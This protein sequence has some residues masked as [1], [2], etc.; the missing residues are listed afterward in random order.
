[1][2]ENNKKYDMNLIKIEVLNLGIQDISNYELEDTSFKEIERLTINKPYNCSK[3]PFN[4]KP[5]CQRR[6]YITILHCTSSTNNKN[7]SLYNKSKKI[8]SPYDISLGSR[9]NFVVSTLFILQML[10]LCFILFLLSIFSSND[11]F[12]YHKTIIT[13]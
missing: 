7:C 13:F 1:M 3:N 6:T 10:L 8:E 12:S 9:E 2:V 4:V 5:I 11:L